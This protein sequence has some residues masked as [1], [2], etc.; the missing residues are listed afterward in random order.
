MLRR[1]KMSEGKGKGVTRGPFGVEVT[2]G[3]LVQ[4][5][6]ELEKDLTGYDKACLRIGELEQINLDLKEEL[7]ECKDTA[8]QT[9]RDTFESGAIEAW[10]EENTR[11]KEQVRELARAKR[12]ISD[13]NTEAGIDNGKVRDK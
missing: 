4:R 10:R 6:A 7:A 9:V 8:I 11:L 3:T 12:W 1:W 13:V 2:K 5:I